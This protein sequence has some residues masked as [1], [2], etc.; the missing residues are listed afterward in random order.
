MVHSAIPALILWL[1]HAKPTAMCSLPNP[2]TL[3]DRPRRFR[4]PGLRPMRACGAARNQLNTTARWEKKASALGL[5]QRRIFVPVHP[6]RQPGLCIPKSV[7]RGLERPSC[8]RDSNPSV[9]V[10]ELWRAP[11]RRPAA[12]LANRNPQHCSDI[13]HVQPDP[14]QT[15]AADRDPPSLAQSSTNDCSRGWRPTVSNL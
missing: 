4:G 8:R 1:R 7:R 10:D 11:H 14:S 15:N 13:G 12:H 3:C 2:R 6:D 9:P 5:G